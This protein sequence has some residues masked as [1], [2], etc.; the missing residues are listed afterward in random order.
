MLKTFTTDEPELNI[1]E[2]SNRLDIGV[3]TAHRLAS[4]LLHEGFLTKDPY[5]KMYRPG[6]SILALGNLVSEQMDVFRG[7]TPIL[8]K[9]MEKS[10]ETV[11]I[12][13]LRNTSIIYLQKIESH[14][15]VRLLSHVGKL[16]PVHCTSSGT[17]I[18]AYQTEKEV[19]KVIA[20]G[21]ERYTIKTVTS[22]AQFLQVLDA[23]RSQGYAINIEEFIEGVTSVAAPIRN[24]TGK[25]IASVSIAG[26]TERINSITIPRI[27]KLVT[28]AAKEITHML[29]TAKTIGRM[30]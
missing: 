30:K 18:L 28:D 6:V 17:V 9:L 14:H 20:R 16:N 26:P 15:P 12:G 27:V 3:S 13:I 19:D 23:V 24:K 22:P 21:L 4:T 10:G 5:S 29:G 25:V 1:S 11:H 7:C 8:E 2:L